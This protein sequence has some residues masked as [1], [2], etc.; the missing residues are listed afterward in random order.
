MSGRPRRALVVRLSSIG[1]VVHTLPAWSALRRSWPGAELG[2]AVEPAAAEL[3]ADLPEPPRLHVLP[4]G[5]W[6]RRPW[7]PQAW[8]RARS[9]LAE[10]RRQRYEVAI[11]FQGLIKSALVA[12]ASGAVVHGYGAPDARERW[13]TRLYHETAPQAPPGHVIDRALH[14]AAAAGADAARP[15]RHEFPDLPSAAVRESVDR[16]LRESGTGA[17]VAVHA[18]G[19]WPS[20]RYPG[21][22]WVA[23]ARALHRRTGLRVLW[24]WGPGERDDIAELADTAGAGSR[25]AFPTSLPELAALLRRSRLLIGGDSAP[26]HLAAAVGTP[27]VGLFGPTDPGR[28]GPPAPRDIAV[29]RLLVC[30]HCHRR[31]CPLGTLQCLDEIEP[32]ELV[33]A[34]LR[35][36]ETAGAAAR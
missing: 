34:A 21:L 8:R 28:L 22:R 18:S 31:R 5:R 1:D 13:A 16:R 23:V 24:I 4:L 19:N 26:L 35:R 6:R 33:E 11:D 30:S 10:L 2:W 17:F 29:R 25:L 9:A 3:L 15:G 12:R 7:A 14:L 20:K 36:L 32:G 27:C